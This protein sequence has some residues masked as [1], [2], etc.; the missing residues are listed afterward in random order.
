MRPH[1]ILRYTGMILLFNALFLLLSAVISALH[2]D[3]ALLPLAYSA[4]VAMLF[5]LFPLIFVPATQDISNDEGLVI[6]VASWLLSCL[7]GL[8]PYVM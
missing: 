3:S 8:L 1:V 5:G 7:V 6:V 2:R 4:V